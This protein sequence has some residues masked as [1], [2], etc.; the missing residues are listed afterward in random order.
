MF[1][2]DEAVITKAKAELKSLTEAWKGG[3]CWGT[4]TD[5]KNKRIEGLHAHTGCHSWVTQAF[6]RHC[7]SQTPKFYK[8][9]CTNFLVLTCHTKRMSKASAKAT[10]AIILWMA[11][12][13]KFSKYI[14]NRDDEESLTRDGAVILCGPDGATGGEA[15]WMC[16]VLRYSTEGGKSLDTWL[17]LK[18]GGVNPMLA[19]RICTDIADVQGATFGHSPVTSHLSV[20][21]NQYDCPVEPDLKA[22]AACEPD[23]EATVTGSLFYR[24]GAP[25]KG[26]YSN[27]FEGFCKPVMKSDGWGGEVVGAKATKESLIYH[28]LE[29]QRKVLGEGVEKPEPVLPNKDTVFLEVDM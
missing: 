11:R 2:V 18:E 17:A 14:L 1:E 20:F 13:S 27:T 12:E 28:A 29:W 4:A 10:D 26:V 19:L 8:K 6:N 7:G 25:E 5:L 22:L 24:D 15:M 9:G 16:K 21:G 3:I 23:R